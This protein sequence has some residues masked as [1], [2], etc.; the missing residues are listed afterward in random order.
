MH[1]LRDLRR[2]FAAEFSDWSQLGRSAGRIALHALADGSGT[3][4]TFRSLVLGRSRNR[5]VE[6]WL[7]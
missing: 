1:L 3:Y 6:V 5:R 2:V 4:D 7:R